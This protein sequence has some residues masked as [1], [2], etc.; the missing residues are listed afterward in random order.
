MSPVALPAA[1]AKCLPD[2]QVAVDLAELLHARGEVPASCQ[3]VSR[4]GLPG[5]LLTTYCLC[6][7]D[8]RKLKLRCYENRQV[9]QRNLD[10]RAG[11]DIPGFPAPLG[12]AGRVLLEP[13]IEG[14]PLDPARPATTHLQ[15]AGKLLAQLHVHS[16]PAELGDSITGVQARLGRLQERLQ[17]FATEG[18]MTATQA[19]QLFQLARDAAPRRPRRGLVHR[20]F[21]PENLLWTDAGITCI[22]QDTLDFAP[23]DEDLAR[24]WLL[25]PMDASAW[26]NFLQ[27][28]AA[29]RDPASFL[30]H[31]G[32]WAIYSTASCL[33]YRRGSH[34]EDW[35]MPLSRL[36]ELL[37][38]NSAAVPDFLTD[39]RDACR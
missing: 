9:L 37:D 26:Q 27:G 28:Y 23:F 25:W 39:T 11:L 35:R 3:Q 20:D 1:L 34:D 15:A 4:K 31:F 21:R 2:S 13:W 22:D 19:G 7:E 30:S 5:S 10:L 17:H 8:G 6:L 32:F 18:L 36:R 12:H 16:Y 33:Q 38:P 14:Q 24:V 29:C